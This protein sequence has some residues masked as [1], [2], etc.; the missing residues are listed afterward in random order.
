MTNLTIEKANELFKDVLP[1]ILSDETYNAIQSLPNK[2]RL[3]VVAKKG[4]LL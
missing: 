1:F 4:V 2:Q 3:C